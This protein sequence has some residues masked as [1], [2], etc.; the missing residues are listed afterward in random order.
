MNWN[1][2]VQSAWKQEVEH[3]G[4][5]T[6]GVLKFNKG[7]AI[8]NSTAS[9]L[10]SAYWH[11]MDRMLFG[12]AADKGMC[13]ERWCFAEGGEFGNNTHLH[14]VARAPMDTELFC[15]VA[16]AVWVNFH[17][18]TSSYDYSWIT[19]AVCSTASSIYNT[20]DTWWLRE[21]MIGVNCS[22][23]NTSG[24][25]YKTFDN[26][27]QANRILKRIGEDE[28][29]KANTAVNRQINKTEE[30]WQLRQRLA[31]LRGIQQA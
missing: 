27:A 7:T 2:R 9:A 31:E 12:R 10:Y 15:T 4:Y 23:Q 30:R 22:R 18:Y 3:S 26:K 11:K 25:D 6:V 28:L 14:F 5:N 13:V 16:S 20:K 8:S 24:I 19:P 21:D 29:T 17:T 1:K